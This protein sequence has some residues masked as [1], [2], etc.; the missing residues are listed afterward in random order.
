MES[1]R[2]VTRRELKTMVP[3]RQI[4]EPYVQLRKEGREYIGLC[5]FHTERTPSFHVV[6]EEGFYHCF[7]CRKSGDGVQFLIDHGGMHFADARKFVEGLAG[8]RDLPEGSRPKPRPRPPSPPAGDTQRKAAAVS[9]ARRTWETCIAAEGTLAETY[10]TC[11]GIDVAVFGAMPRA[12]RFSAGLKDGESGRHW[13][14]MVAAIQNDTGELIGV[15]RTFLAYA[16]AEKHPD[17]HAAF[18]AMA[19]RKGQFSHVVTKAP[20]KSPKKMLGMSKGGAIRLA[21]AGATL[22][23]AEGIET[24]LSVMQAME[25]PAWAAM[26]LGNM[27]GIK[28][29]PVVREVVLCADNDAKDPEA[30]EKILKQAADA[31]RRQDVS[32][33]IARPHEG[34]D[35][36]DMLMAPYRT[37][38][39]AHAG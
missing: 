2:P 29:P 25:G 19:G 8:L 22:F 11:R 36:N 17:L 14:A 10:L 3:L 39:V 38:E 24:A 32:V 1:D 18:C 21:P 5:P 30:A 23:I 28:L 6:E 26:S 7:G 33:R 37:R 9:W 4:I 31:Y 15:H 12:I 13:P 20:I 34:K 27:G 16:P 35:F